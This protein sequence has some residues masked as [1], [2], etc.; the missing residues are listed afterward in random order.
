WTE[1]G[2][3][4]RERG[5]QRRHL[6]LPEWTAGQDVGVLGTGVW[7]A[8]P[9]AR[10]WTH[11][12]RRQREQRELQLAPWHS[13]QR[14]RVELHARGRRPTGTRRLAL[15]ER[16]H[17]GAHDA[18]RQSFRELVLPHLWSLQPRGH[19]RGGARC[20]RLRERRE[21]RADRTVWLAR[22]ALLR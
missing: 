18:S 9:D 13:P 20:A 10:S 6:H 17:S 8:R 12:R 3:Y 11:A 4:P 2:E 1:R 22:G 21:Q 7:R 16:L 5:K 14:H 19:R 15:R